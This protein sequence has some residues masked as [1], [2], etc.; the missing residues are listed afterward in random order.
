LNQTEEFAM[1]R[2]KQAFTLT[3]LLIALG[4]IGILC[5]ILLPIIFNLMPNQNTIMAK[6]AYYAVQTIV[7]DM[8]NDDACYPDKTSSVNNAK[9]GFD[10]AAGSAN[11]SQW[12][13]DHLD[14]TSMSKAAEK[15]QAIFTDKMGVSDSPSKFSTSDGIYWV[16]TDAGFSSSSKTGG[17]ISILVDVN[18]ASSGPN[19]GGN[20]TS[21]TAYSTEFGSGTDEACK[22]RTTG[23]DR[24]KI[25][26]KGDGGVSINPSDVWA[27]NAVKVD[28]NI[29][30]DKE[31][32]DK[33]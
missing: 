12:D 30:S 7:S 27:V 21:V 22:N 6:R 17:S 15:F 8:I 14:D 28:R 13:E 9:V 29:T 18:G 11:C 5:V 24:F 26:V 32:N 4:V 2:N 20:S 25:I 31:S 3:E 10:D 1:R 16:I 19:C 23:F 33:D